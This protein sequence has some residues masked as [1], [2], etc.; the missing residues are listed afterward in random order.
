M[1]ISHAP[2]D[3]ITFQVDNGEHADLVCLDSVENSVGKSAQ[4]GVP[5]FAMHNF[6]LLRVTCYPLQCGINLGN[7]LSSEAF[8]LSFIPFCGPADITLG[9]PSDQ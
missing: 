5:D 7:E 9:A 8:P 2:Q 1:P 3:L 4:N 6:V